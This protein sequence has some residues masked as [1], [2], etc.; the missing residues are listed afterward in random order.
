MIGKILGYVALLILLSPIIVPF[1]QLIGTIISVFI[2]DPTNEHLDRLKKNITATLKSI[3]LFK[4]IDYRMSVK[5]KG[6]NEF[7]INLNI[8]SKYEIDSIATK[9]IQMKDD[10]WIIPF[11]ASQFNLNSVYENTFL[12]FYHKPTG[13]EVSVHLLKS[14]PMLEIFT[15]NYE[16]GRKS[17]RDWKGF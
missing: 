17:G 14:E 3:A 13:M 4:Y 15:E 10:E 9:L 5:Q 7:R 2:P 16:K 6:E 12:D 11:Q 8:Y 1:L